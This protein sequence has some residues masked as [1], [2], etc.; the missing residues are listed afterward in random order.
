VVDKFLYK[1]VLKMKVKIEKNEIMQL[2]EDIY[3]K[4]GNLKAFC[5]KYK[6]SYS[7]VSWLFN[8]PKKFSLKYWVKITK[9]L[10]E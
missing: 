2:L 9:V 4:S 7:Y 1:G 5:E 10:E 8:H 6:L 3:R